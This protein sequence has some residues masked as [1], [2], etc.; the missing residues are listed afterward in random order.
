M[1]ANNVYP[2]SG[3]YPFHLE[4]KQMEQ[5]G[6]KHAWICPMETI[7]YNCWTNDYCHSLT[8][9]PLYFSIWWSQG[10]M[11]GVHSMFCISLVLAKCGSQSETAV[12]RCLWWGIILRSPVFPPMLWDLVFFVSSV[13]PAERDVRYSFCCFCLVF[14]VLKIMNTDHAAPWSTS[15]HDRHNYTLY[16]L[17][18]G[19][20]RRH[21]M[22]RCL[23]MCQ[24][25]TSNLSLDQFAPTL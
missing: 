16:Q 24:S 18:A 21:W 6:D 13:K 10:V 1:K 22:C 20:N 2:W 15:S 12:Y 4:R 5:N 23:S 7:V 17:N 14:W 11:W 3:V 9:E 25:V 8:L 19:N